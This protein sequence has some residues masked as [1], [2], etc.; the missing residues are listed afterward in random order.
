MSIADEIRKLQ[1]L[2]RTGALT[3]DEFTKA[4][5]AVLAGSA[6]D[7][8]AFGGA[9]EA[10]HEVAEQQLAEL[11]LQNAV[12]RLDREW[13]L[14]REQYMIANNYGVRQIPSQGVSIIGG[15]AVVGFGIFWTIMAANMGGGFGGAFDIFPLF[16]V[17]FIVAG[18]GISIYSFT[19]ASQYQRANAEY[20]RRRRQLLS[21]GTELAD[22]T[23]ERG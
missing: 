19:K 15:A 5:A 1:E 22:S 11:R 13:Q 4:K 12:D 3:E 17:I 8:A 18:I 2:R 21:G 23:E 7:G 14:Q 6:A 9:S 20:Q 16:G 10:G